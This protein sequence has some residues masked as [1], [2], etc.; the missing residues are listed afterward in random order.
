MERK[1]RK[2]QIKEPRFCTGL[3]KKDQVPVLV[4]KGLGLSGPFNFF[5]AAKKSSR[6]GDWR[7]LTAR[8]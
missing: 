7:G 2:T 8:T 4:R 5:L 6:R 3:Y 1:N